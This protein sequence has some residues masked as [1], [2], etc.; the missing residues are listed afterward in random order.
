MPVWSS[1]FSQPAVS[2]RSQ[3]GSEREKLLSLS[4][5]MSSNLYDEDNGSWLVGQGKGGC[6]EEKEE[7][8]HFEYFRG[9]TGRG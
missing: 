7:E 6:E 1:D 2:G 5:G 8:G 4:Q 3:A 9:G